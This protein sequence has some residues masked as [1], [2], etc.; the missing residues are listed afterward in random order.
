MNSALR[1]LISA[2]GVGAPE[3]IIVG[4]TRVVT[5]PSVNIAL[6]SGLQA[7]DSVF[8][9]IIHG[10]TPGKTVTPP[11]GWQ[12]WQSNSS[13]FS[14]AI[15]HKI[16]G[17][18][19]DSTYYLSADLTE[20]SVMTIA[21]RIPGYAVLL[22]R[23]D[24][25]SDE[26][27]TGST[28]AIAPVR[29]VTTL[30]ENAFAIAVMGYVSNV[31]QV[32]T[33]PS[34]FGD[35]ETQARL[36]NGDTSTIAVSHQTIKDIGV[37]DVGSYSVQDS[38]HWKTFAAVLR[39][40]PCFI[41]D[42]FTI[43][44]VSAGISELAESV[45]ISP[46]GFDATVQI[47]ASAGAQVSI[48][49][50]DWVSSGQIDPGES[51]VARGTSPGAWGDTVSYQITVG[52]SPAADLTIVAQNMLHFIAEPVTLAV[53]GGATSARL[54]AVG[55]GGGSGARETGS[56]SA[57]GGGGAMAWG[58]FSV[59][60]GDIIEA[61]IDGTDGVGGV[62][63]GGFLNRDGKAG[64]D[65][66]IRIN[67]VTMI[68]AKGGS[69]GKASTGT[70]TY[71]GGLGGAASACVGPNKQSGGNGGS[72][73]STIAGAGGGAGGYSGPGGR[74]ASISLTAQ[75]G[76][77]GA[78]GGGV[79]VNGSISAG[80]GGGVGLYGEG[81]SG[82]AGTTASY[83]TANG[84]S[85]SIQSPWPDLAAQPGG[86]AGGKVAGGHGSNGRPPGFAI[87]WS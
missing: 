36:K 9:F 58:D 4:T 12:G 85:G 67:G 81:S 70:G 13:D 5:G 30:S 74:G 49:G 3:A 73:A 26:F 28:G 48:S 8:V 55:G 20:W 84:V 79:Y 78:G 66:T 87:I 32:V 75:S 23:F 62:D 50:G 64:S 83:S 71:A 65:V 17:A 7:G 6:P 29:D 40:T 68:L 1:M 61:S 19:P 51:F 47:S 16:M 34:G 72:G 56:A 60:P 10:G 42:P 54:V 2:G 14:F 31:E 45:P 46:V 77:G 80:Y 59:S 24:D 35:M 39:V 27:L 11:E 76:Q 43:P 86:G 22:E 15:N 38:G 57:G 41:A 82:A 25:L 18:T 33:P 69:G 37:V 44:I 53:P 52:D 63:G 21:Y